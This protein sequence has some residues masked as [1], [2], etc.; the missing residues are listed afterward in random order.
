MDR[1][2]SF[3][4][5]MELSRKTISQNWFAFFL[6]GLVAGL[7]SLA[8]VLACVIGLFVTVPLS[9]GMIA[10]AYEDTFGKQA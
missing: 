10:Y 8:G 6:L 9:I 7:V 4:D 2:L 1:K 5:G 3:W